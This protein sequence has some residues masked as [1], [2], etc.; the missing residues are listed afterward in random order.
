MQTWAKNAIAVAITCPLVAACAGEADNATG[1]A[2]ASPTT[3]GNRFE[4]PAAPLSKLTT[5]GTHC[6]ATSLDAAAAAGRIA[7][8][9]VADRLDYEGQR[10]VANHGGPLPKAMSDMMGEVSDPDQDNC[11]AVSTFRYEDRWWYPPPPG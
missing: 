4:S 1:A 11:V 10:R 9:F 7:A 2:P 8:A 3:T 6:F 5:A